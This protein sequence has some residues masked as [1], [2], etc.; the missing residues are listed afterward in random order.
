MPH[1]ESFYAACGFDTYDTQET[2]F[3]HALMMKKDLRSVSVEFVRNHC[4]GD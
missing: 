3:G 1:A 4:L 2:R